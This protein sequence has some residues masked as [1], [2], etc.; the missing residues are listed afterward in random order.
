MNN[1]QPRKR[2]LVRIIWSIAQREVL[3]IWSTKS[4][5]FLVVSTP[6]FMSGVLFLTWPAIGFMQ[7]MMKDSPEFAAQFSAVQRQDLFD[8]LQFQVQSVFRGE[9]LH[10]YIR[11]ETGQDFDEAIRYKILQ[12]DYE[13]YL[14]SLSD[15]EQ[16]PSIEQFHDY[17]YERDFF[18]YPQLTVRRHHEI[19]D[20]ELTVEELNARLDRGEISGYF[21]IPEDFTE[22]YDGAQFIRPKSTTQA[23]LNKLNELELWIE[24]VFFEVLRELQLPSHYVQNDELRKNIYR[25]L[26]IKIE[27]VSQ[28]QDGS[29]NTEDDLAQQ[30]DS[31]AVGF[32]L[33]LATI[34]FL[35]LFM[36]V[37]SNIS[38]YVLANT[39]EEKSS[40]AAEMLI[41]RLS[42]I[43]I[44]DGKLLGCGLIGLVGV[45][46]FCVLVG[47]PLVLVLNSVLSPTDIVN[48]LH[49]MKLVNWVL[50]L[51]IGFLTFGYVQSAL[52]SLCDDDKDFRSVFLP[53]TLLQFIGIWPSVI[54]VLMDPGGKVAQVLSFVPLISPYVMV[55][56]TALLPDWPTYLL[57]MLV[58][59]LSMYLI[60]RFTLR[61]YTIGLTS[62]RAPK[63]YRRL[64]KLSRE[65]S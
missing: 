44:M 65:N 45:A 3:S 33:K 37:L 31:S 32:W 36:S 63:S 42:P 10:Y 54:F 30:G 23:T 29:S 38:N 25:P 14:K 56:R 64:V 15:S 21:V 58:M 53:M 11:D 7:T 4:Y 6:L 51:V 26:P 2:F 60:R 28:T 16:P 62:E 40:K 13:L 8:E 55:S 43:T 48:F 35:W 41:S 17:Y 50:C 57:I 5:W 1:D 46:A 19:Q 39:L 47:P 9:H 59:C 61:V 24:Q 12:T 18:G 22:S 27:K 52:G 49:P 20:R 34:P